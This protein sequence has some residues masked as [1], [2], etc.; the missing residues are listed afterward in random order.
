MVERLVL[1][2]GRF[3]AAKNPVG[4]AAGSS[5]EPSHDGGH[6]G[7]WLEDRVDVIGHDHPRVEFVESANGLTVQECVRNHAGNSRI[8]QPNWA[9]SLA[10]ESLIV[11]KKSRWDRRSFFVVCQAPVASDNLRSGR[12]RS[13]KT[14]G[15][16]NRGLLWNPVR[17]VSAGEGHKHD[18]PQKTMVCPTWNSVLSYAGFSRK[19]PTSRWRS[20]R[21]PGLTKSSD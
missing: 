15:H 12:K 11:P 18:R 3:S 14:P 1:P 20:L 16:E 9:G 19:C 7:V 4:H 17:Q 5:F 6:F 21:D 8:L 13:G 2:E 10:V